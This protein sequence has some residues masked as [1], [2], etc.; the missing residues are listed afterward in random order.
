MKKNNIPP[1]LELTFAAG[2]MIILSL[3][4]FV[5]AQDHKEFSVSINNKDTIVNGKNI[6]DL[7]AADR[8][9]A[10]KKL[11]E[12]N[13]RISFTT[14]DSGDNMI[15]L[16]QKDGTSKVYVYGNGITVG[17]IPPMP[18]MTAYNLSIDTADRGMIIA[19]NVIKSD[20][21]TLAGSKLRTS[22][23]ANGRGLSSVFLSGG[24]KNSQSFSYSNTD[25][26]GINT[27]I[28]FN[29]SDASAEKIKK[30]SGAEKADLNIQDL[31]IV[32]SFS[33]G[34]TTL[35]F[36]LPA[37]GAEVQFKD[38][39]GNVLWTEKITGNEFSKSFA[40]PKN[41]VYYL[42]VKQAGKVA[43]RRIAKEE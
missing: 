5:K 9:D 33:T 27:H 26:D 29:V 16:K 34:K 35:I 15:T 25:N 18:P 32:P 42:Q 4:L 21:K 12:L 28:N 39:E 17:D 3:P 6:K 2:V 10:L 24:R 30:I 20:F 7:S 37:K 43:L 38:S 8:T 22:V 36:N 14:K 13:D 11:N 41:G 1:I 31:S 23:L 19:D 40:L